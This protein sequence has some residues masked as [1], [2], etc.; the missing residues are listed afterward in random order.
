MSAAASTRVG[1]P[2]L[3]ATG[4]V[5]VGLV[6]QEVGAAFAVTLFPSVGA[7]GMVSLRL[8]F[9]AAILML[10]FRPRLRGRSRA[11]W[12]TVVMFGLSLAGMN[13]LFYEALARLPL[14]VTVTIEV[15]GPLIL[16][17]VVSRRASSWLWA[18]LAFAG[19]ALLGRGGLD[20][21]DPIGVLFAAGTGAL[22]VAY[23]L[24]SA[25]T[26]RRFDRL[27]GL[28]LAMTVGALV[29]VPFGTVTAGAAI[30]R[31]QV[32]LLGLA[33]AVL[34]S[35][36][37]YGLELLALRRLPAATFSILLSLAPVLAA[38]AGLVIL[39]QPLQLLDLLAMILVVAASM[40]AVRA[41][42]GQTRNMTSEVTP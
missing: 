20:S 30:I 8:A 32:L 6:C 26:G 34:S 41:A 42:R 25:R 11:D 38:I 40:G 23:I 24:L 13:V 3:G 36:I 35:T 28:A 31:P 9:S 29:V 1:G 39:R 2:A 37:P 16:S 17:V 27:D 10:I 5:V 19:V 22:W 18:L 33:V 21:L 12:M 14:G 15:L 7:V 4:L